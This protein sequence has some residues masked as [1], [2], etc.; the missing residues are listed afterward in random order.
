MPPAVESSPVASWP[1]H[2]HTASIRLCLEL[3]ACTCLCCCVPVSSCAGMY[4]CL[5]GFIDPCEGIEE[6]VRREVM[7]EARVQVRWG[8][9]ARGLRLVLGQCG[10][11]GVRL[12]VGQLSPAVSRQYSCDHLQVCVYMVVPAM[13]VVMRV[14]LW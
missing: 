2:T 6:A 1:A 5:S 11:C 14:V 8:W 3:I 13:E 7:E 12:L 10:S 9:V 4:T